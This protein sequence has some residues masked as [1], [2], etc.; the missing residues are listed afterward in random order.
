MTTVLR[1]TYIHHRFRWLRGYGKKVFQQ[2][3]ALSGE[4]NLTRLQQMETI[5]I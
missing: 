5:G 3:M 4:N 1:G 2:L